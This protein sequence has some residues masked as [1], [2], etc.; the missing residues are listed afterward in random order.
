M[1]FRYW[2]DNIWTNNI[3][4]TL[5]FNPWTE[6]TIENINSLGNY[7]GIGTFNIE[8]TTFFKIQQFYLDLWPC[9]LKVNG[10]HSNSRG[11]HCTKFGNFQ[12]KGSNS[13]EQTSLRLQTDT[14][15]NMSFLRKNKLVSEKQ[16]KPTK[17]H[18]L[19]H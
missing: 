5:T 4:L 13:I 6:K 7:K 14:Q 11:I 1:A 2:A 10:E 3:T 15:N 8:Q 12:G 19:T 18:M 16:Q 17:L 9:D